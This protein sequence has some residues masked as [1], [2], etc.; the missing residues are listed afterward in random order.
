MFPSTNPLTIKSA[1]L[2]GGLMLWMGQRNRAP[3]KGWLKHVETL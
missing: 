3:T 1:K 2:S